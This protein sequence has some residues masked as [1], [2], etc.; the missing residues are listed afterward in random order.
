MN[1]RTLFVG[2]SALMLA[3]LPGLAQD[4]ANPAEISGF[5]AVSGTKIT[6]GSGGM[7]T[8]EGVP[9]ALPIVFDG[10]APDL[11]ATADFVAAWSGAVQVAAGAT[12]ASGVEEVELAATVTSARLIGSQVEQGRLVDYVIGLK[13]E[14][15]ASDGMGLGA[16]TFMISDLR[17]LEARDD[18]GEALTAAKLPSRLQ[19][20]NFLL[21]IDLTP[22]FVEALANGA[23]QAE[24]EAIGQGRPSGAKPCRPA[25]ARRRC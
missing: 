23:V 9:N 12:Q 25:A 21:Y 13:L 7:L 2:V 5:I 20:D 8:L 11:Y 15:V 3:A 4:S 18:K 22:A 14:A 19:M 16:L 6:L 24:A 1:F 10:L 17:L